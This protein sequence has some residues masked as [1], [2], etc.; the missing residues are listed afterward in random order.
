MDDVRLSIHGRT[1]IGQVRN[2]NEDSIRWYTAHNCPFGYIVIADGMG[3]YTGGALAST[4]AVNTIGEALEGLITPTFLALTPLQQ[5]LM[6]S[7]CAIECIRS[8]NRAILEQKQWNSR[9]EHMGTTVVLVVVWQNQAIVAHLGDSRAYLWD[10]DHFIQLTKDHSIVQ[11]MIDAGNMTEEEARTSNI[12]NQITQ[13]LGIEQDVTPT[14]NSYILNQNTLIMMCS[15]GLTE[16]LGNEE[17][18][19]VL[20]THRP[21]IECCDRM[22]DDANGRGGKDNISVGIIEYTMHTDIDEGNDTLPPRHREDDDDEDI[23]VKLY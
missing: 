18:D 10:Q 17:L 1:H 23:T 2:E 7:S 11:E 8:A 22:V 6:I 12:R 15:D 13:A 20:S 19:F 3:G 9:F 21:A 14:M 5:Q 4:I 16:Y